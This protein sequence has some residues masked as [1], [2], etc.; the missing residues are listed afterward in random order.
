M[1]PATRKRA[2][3]FSPENETSNSCPNP[4][5]APVIRILLPAKR[6]TVPYISNYFLIQFSA[7]RGIVDGKKLTIN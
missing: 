7:S 1:F 5:E 4:A 6:F 2:S 3:A